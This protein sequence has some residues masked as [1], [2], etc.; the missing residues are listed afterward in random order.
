MASQDASADSDLNVL[1][2][3]P[4]RAYPPGMGFTFSKRKRLGKSSTLNLSKSGASVSKRVGRVTV[5]S[6]GRGSV[7]IGK[8]LGFRFKI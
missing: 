5:N 7:R 1:T 3:S 2:R 4:C 8:G 6:R